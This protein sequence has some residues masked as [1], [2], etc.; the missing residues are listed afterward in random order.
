MSQS[1][2]DK[3]LAIFRQA[4]AAVESRVYW[5]PFPENPAAFGEGAV[6]EGYAAFEAYRDASFYLDQPGVVGRA[7]N[8]VSPYGIPLTIAYPQCNPDALILGGKMAMSSWMKAGPE[9]RIG[10]CLEILFR[11]RAHSMELAHAVMHTTGQPFNLAFQVSVAQAMDRGLEA[12]ACSWREMKQV[13]SRVLWEKPHGKNPPL[14]LDKQFMVVPRGVGL[15]IGSAV[16]PTWSAF[17][18]I[19]ANLATGNPVIVKPHHEVILP[20]AI[21]VAVARMVLKESG[22]DPNLVSLL[23]D[24]EAGAAARIVSLKPEVRIIDYTGHSAMGE[25]LEENARQAVV[26]SQKSSLNCVVVDS[27][28]DYKGLLRNLALSMCLYSGQIAAAPRL[29]FVSREGVRTPDG[30]QSSEQFGRDLAQ[31]IGHLMEDPQRAMELL[32]CLQSPD[33]QARIDEARE[34]GEVLRDSSVVATDRWLNAR[35]ATPLL[36]RATVGDEDRYAQHRFGPIYWV[37]ETMT[38]AESLAAAER[39]MN[40]KGGL[41]LAVH[42]T[43]PH[44]QEMG[45]EMAARVGVSLHVNLTG[46]ALMSLP[47]PYSDFHGSGVNPAANCCFTDSAFIA[48]R[49]FLIH[50]QRIAG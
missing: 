39:A 11:L 41:A 50:S 24:E 21:V 20:L 10:V 32:G 42:S 43:S 40:S 23:V 7:G 18:A 1:L 9:D 13:P 15:V 37:V 6:E 17:P 31:T 28:D 16:S 36:L 38:T 19:F 35:C 47:A 29:I 8:E 2:F 3:H 46:A 44:V 12:L 33:T 48:Q 34:A 5:S 30:V 27:T 14:R 4:V 22:F 49:F 26:F 25:W 45:Q